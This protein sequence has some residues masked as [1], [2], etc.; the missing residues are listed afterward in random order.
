MARIFPERLPESI[1]N[2]PKRAAE[3]KLYDCLAQ[4]SK[5]YTVYYSVTWQARTRDGNVRD[6]EA[7]FVVTHPDYGLLVIEVKGGGISFESTTSEWFSQDRNG[8]THPIKDPIDQA[9]TSKHELLRKLT[10]M[11]GW[12]NRWL[13]VA[14]AVAFPDIYAPGKL[15]RPDLPAE[16]ILDANALNELEPAIQRIFRYYSSGDG[17]S[18]ALGYDRS[19][20]VESLL[21]RSFQIKTPL[22]VELA[23]ED[24]RLV[25]L[26]ERQMMILD[27]L[28]NRRRAAIKG[29]AGSGKT[30]LAVEKARRLAT[31]GFEVLLTCYNY[32]LAEDLARRIPEGVTVTHFHGLCREMSK[33][34]GYTIRSVADNR[35]F[36]NE[37]MPNALLEAIDQL[38]PQYDAII[39]DEGQD[40]REN[41]WLPIVSLL[42]DPDQGLLYVF[43][44]DNQ[45]I[46][47]GLDRLPGVIE[48][49]PFSLMEN[50]R[51]T[52]KIHSVVA[53]FYHSPGQLHC[54]GPIGRVPEML[55]YRGERHMFRVVQ[56]LLHKLVVEE[57]I[58]PSDLVILTPRSHTRTALKTDLPIG[59]F[60]LSSQ[61]PQAANQIQVSSIH[62]FKGLERRVVIIAEIDRE[63]SS[64]LTSLLYVACS[65]ART[66]LLVLM[67]AELPEFA[68]EN[69]R[70][71][72]R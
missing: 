3:R 34:A 11:P 62:T 71:M 59:S 25:E 17:R 31:Q 51:N 38:G 49:A 72:A 47:R 50:C 44:D 54:R 53:S 8:V 30:M 22:G 24:E 40:F 12:D 27:F 15:L 10:D 6:G 16:I 36:Y 43:Y 67:D 60:R 13:T 32:A 46:Y 65:R 29:C 37:I 58:S 14:H 20:I 5:S 35:Q 7:D 1:L 55:E 63:A 64:D 9:R 70:R 61:P 39:V 66:H 33:Q 4:L 18:G 45:N 21:A 26:T 41:W 57:H 52:Q 68:K 19:E 2:D 56:H 42:R 28:S 48:E 23:Y 69:I